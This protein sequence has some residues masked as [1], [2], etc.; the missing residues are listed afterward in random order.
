MMVQSGGGGSEMVMMLQQPPSTDCPPR[1]TTT[2][3]LTWSGSRLEQRPGERDKEGGLGPV[4]R[5]GR[6][7]GGPFSLMMGGGDGQDS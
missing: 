6:L 1:P 7:G 3:A 4:V 5:T 2:T